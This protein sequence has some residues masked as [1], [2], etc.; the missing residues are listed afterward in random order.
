MF[1]GRD[2]DVG[3]LSCDPLRRAPGKSAVIIGI[4]F[5]TSAPALKGNVRCRSDWFISRY[6]QTTPMSDEAT[7]DQHILDLRRA[8]ESFIPPE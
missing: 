2:E 7:S 8:Q 1:Y 4:R 6:A 5:R 3:L